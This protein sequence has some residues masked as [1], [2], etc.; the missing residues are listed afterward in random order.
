M[1]P[2]EAIEELK[3]ALAEAE[4]HVDLLDTASEAVATAEAKLQTINDQIEKSQQDLKAAQAAHDRALSANE[5][6]LA[7]SEAKT[8]EALRVHQ[9]QIQT[10]QDKLAELNVVYESKLR[11]HDHLLASLN[12]L[13]KRL[14]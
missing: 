8:G 6:K 14:A 4:Q 12:S 7:A 1:K 2:S 11:D 5:S 3:A 10:V 13:K 9:G